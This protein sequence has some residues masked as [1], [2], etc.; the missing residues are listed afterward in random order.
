MSRESRQFQVADGWMDLVGKF[1]E[2]TPLEACPGVFTGPCETKNRL[3]L[4]L[5]GATL[6][7]TNLVRS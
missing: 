2:E 6:R 3:E 7:T 5:Q 1:L 4:P